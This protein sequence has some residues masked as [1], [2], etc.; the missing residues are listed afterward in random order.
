MRKMTLTAPYDARLPIAPDG[1]GK[2]TGDCR[3]WHFTPQL[4]QGVIFLSYFSW[5]T[6]YCCE[7]EETIAKDDES[8]SQKYPRVGPSGSSAR[9]SGQRVQR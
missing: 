8:R 6:V 1:K 2:V 4:S 5:K 9:A 7:R 3:M